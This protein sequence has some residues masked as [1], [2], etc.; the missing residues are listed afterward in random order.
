MATFIFGENKLEHPFFVSFEIG[1]KNLSIA[2]GVNEKPGQKGW[3]INTI[4][5]FADSR[6]AKEMLKGGIVLHSGNREILVKLK[7]A[8][9]FEKIQVFIDGNKI[10]GHQYIEFKL[11]TC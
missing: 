5:T 2:E 3:V 6:E 8:F 4:K 9:I 11:V 1:Y 10:K 7:R